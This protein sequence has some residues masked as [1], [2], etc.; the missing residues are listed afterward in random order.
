MA[1]YARLD[2]V[3]SVYNG[4]IESVK[5]KQANLKIENGMVGVAGKLLENEREIREFATPTAISDKLILI[6][7]DEINYKDSSATDRALEAF[8]GLTAEESASRAYHLEKA[9]VFSISKDMFTGTVVKDKFVVA[10]AGSNKLEVLA[11]ALTPSATYG[12]VGVIEGIE[13]FGT[14][15]AVGQAGN[16]SRPTELVVITVLQN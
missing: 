11:G 3:K 8:T 9:D 12:F 6:A 14:T 4:N 7:N 2:K 1:G 5:H 16:I 13:K 10:K 15:V